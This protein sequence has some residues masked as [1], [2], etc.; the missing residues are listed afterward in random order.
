MRI[1]SRHSGW[2]REGFTGESRQYVS[3]W[4]KV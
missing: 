3:I 2:S 1:V 4:E